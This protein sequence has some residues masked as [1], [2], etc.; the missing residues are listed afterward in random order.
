MHCHRNLIECTVTGTPSVTVLHTF[1][2][3]RSILLRLALKIDYRRNPNRG[4]DGDANTTT[5]HFR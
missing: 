1:V 2:E 4:N 5:D 3:A